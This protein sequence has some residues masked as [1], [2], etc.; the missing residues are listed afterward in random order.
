M[1]NDTRSAY[2]P[3]DSMVISGVTPQSSQSRV[4]ALSGVPVCQRTRA[5]GKS[6]AWRS[7]ISAGQS[8]GGCMSCHPIVHSESS[9]TVYAT[10]N[11]LQRVTI[12]AALF[13]T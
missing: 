10:A 13:A 4:E 9:Q 5:V 12:V 11:D 1:S 3:D 8:V 6:S 7:R 2:S